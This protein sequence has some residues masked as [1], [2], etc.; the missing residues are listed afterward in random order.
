MDSL[1]LTL[2]SC[3]LIAAVAVSMLD[4]AKHFNAQLIQLIKCVI[5]VY[6]DLPFNREF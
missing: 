1:K 4:V 3:M 5:C 6:R 2:L